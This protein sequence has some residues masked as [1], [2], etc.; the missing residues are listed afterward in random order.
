MSSCNIYNYQVILVLLHADDV[1]DNRDDN[2]WPPLH[3]AAQSNE[4]SM[5]IYALL[6]GG[7]D[8]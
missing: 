2:G 3:C 6:D 5:V 4:N 7:A 1:I 8:A